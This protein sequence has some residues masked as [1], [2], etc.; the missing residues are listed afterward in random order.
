LPA[1]GKADRSGGRRET[2]RRIRKAEQFNQRE[3]A[4]KYRAKAQNC[5]NYM[6]TRGKDCAA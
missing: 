1:A 5:A 4:G 3:N 2:H 6:K